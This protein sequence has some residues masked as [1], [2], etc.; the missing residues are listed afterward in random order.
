MEKFKESNKD[1]W[2]NIMKAIHRN[3][4]LNVALKTEQTKIS[5]L[6]PV[7]KTKPM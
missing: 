2:K 1:R 6:E 4:N 3:E 7:C 5:A